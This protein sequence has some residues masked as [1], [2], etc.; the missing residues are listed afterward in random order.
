M[1][2]ETVDVGALSVNTGG[3]NIDFVGTVSAPSVDDILL[4]S[5]IPETLLLA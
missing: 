4:T 2:D 1:I 5:S 3:S